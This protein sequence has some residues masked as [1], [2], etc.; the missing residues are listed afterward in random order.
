MLGEEI[1]HP[2]QDAEVMTN[3]LGTAMLSWPA[4]ELLGR[5]RMRVMEI[6]ALFR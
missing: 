1:V 4:G 2:L 3:S 6:G 5:A